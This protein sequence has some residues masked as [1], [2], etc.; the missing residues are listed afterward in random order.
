MSV[1]GI[2]LTRQTS[3]W[4]QKN[5]EEPKRTTRISNMVDVKGLVFIF[6]TLLMERSG[7]LKPDGGYCIENQCFTVFQDPSDYPTSRDQC[8]DLG[9]HLMTVRS[10]VSHDILSNL[11]GKSKGRFWIGLHL[12]TGCPDLT[13]ELRGFQ[14]VT[15]DSESEFSDWV[16]DFDSSCSSLRCVSVSQE[17][18]FKWMQEPC[19]AHGAGFLCEHTVKEPCKSLAVTDKDTV[20][21]N[22]SLGFQAE[23]LP[24]AP[25]GSIAIRMPAE[26]KYVCFSEQ[27]VQAPWSCEIQDGGCEY[28][29]SVNSEKE[30]TCYCPPG[31]TINPANGVTC[32]VSAEDPCLNLHCMHAC[33]QEGDIHKCVCHH[34]YKLAPDGRSCV[35]FDDCKDERQCPGENFKCV[36]TPGDFQCVCKD[37]Y[38]LTGGACVDVDECVSAP[39]EHLCANSPGNYT[40]SCYDGYK[41]DPEEPHKCKLYCG[42]EECDAECDPNNMYQCYCPDGYIAEERGDKTVC[43]DID[44]CVFFYCDQECENTFGSY[45]CGCSR[46][47]TLEGKYKCVKNE[48]DTD[49]DGSGTGATTPPS[50]PPV[51]YPNPTKRPSGLSPGGLAG[52]IICI[53]I[54]IV[55]VVFLAHH[56]L[57]GRDKRKSANE[58]P[59]VLST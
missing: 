40:C 33:S 18:D 30:P 52:I 22:S 10:P 42:K 43:I 11:L 59:M 53:A 24:S 5:T 31:H 27:W 41:E 32:E 13:T 47:F 9:G 4:T 38:K 7:A 3:L 46:G 51:T 17:E 35:D 12:P 34:G 20:I 44:E 54:F 23:N 25:P 37:G 29:C 19:D 2:C 56:I 45:V 6:L 16:P 26:T 15:K 36:N 28:K 8:R 58:G 57:C 55:L 1:S 50:I 14:W 21:Y 48:D 39:C 49:E